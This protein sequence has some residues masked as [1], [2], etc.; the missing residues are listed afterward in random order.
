MP[1]DAAAPS[2]PIAWVR[3]RARIRS[4]GAVRGDAARAGNDS[5]RGRGRIRGLDQG[6][7]MASGE[8]GVIEAAEAPPTV[9]EADVVIVGLG[10]EIGRA[11]CRERVCS[12]V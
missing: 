8:Y 4:D 6:E 12:V 2:A 10:C 5:E 11:S 9:D 1:G 7:R 3:L